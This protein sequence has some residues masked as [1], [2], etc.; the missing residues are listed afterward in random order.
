MKNWKLVDFETRFEV[1]HKP[2]FPRLI[3]QSGRSP[4]LILFE[5]GLWD[6]RAFRELAKSHK[7]ADELP[8]TGLASPRRHITWQESRFF[9]SRMKKFIPFM[10]NVFGKDVPM[11][12][13]SLTTHNISDSV[14]LVVF[15][16]DRVSRFLTKKFDLEIFEWSR[17]I[18]GHTSFYK[19]RTHPGKNPVSW[20]WANMVFNYL[21]RSL[22]GLEVDG[23][24][25][26]LPSKEFKGYGGWEECHSWNLLYN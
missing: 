1:Q 22:G 6:E 8:D 20:L 23:R 10:R 2:T 7:A 26:R 4:D 17:I 11:M 24:I 25:E 15:D 21:F 9:S 3:G 16:L 12:Y 5:T 19:D 18:R 13:Q 14:D